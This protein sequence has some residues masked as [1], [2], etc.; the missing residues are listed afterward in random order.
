M[1]EIEEVYKTAFF[2]EREVC[3]HSKFDSLSAEE[4]KEI[5]HQVPLDPEEG[6][7]DPDEIHYISQLVAERDNNPAPYGDA[8]AFGGCLWMLC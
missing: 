2:D 3:G 8:E 7:F 6:D 4:L 1:C 5:L